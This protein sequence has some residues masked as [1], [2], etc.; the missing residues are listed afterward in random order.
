MKVS[1]LLEMLK[2]KEDFDI[3]IVESYTDKS[4]WGYTVTTIDFDIADIGYS[5]KTI[6][7]EKKGNIHENTRIIRES[8]E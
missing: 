2:D 8:E 4:E 6:L 1:K 7:I 3:K 5:E